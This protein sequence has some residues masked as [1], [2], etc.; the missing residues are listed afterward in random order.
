MSE[1]CYLCATTR[2]TSTAAAGAACSLGVDCDG[3]RTEA[4]RRLKGEQ[5][6]EVP[7]KKKAGVSRGYSGWADG[8]ARGS[9]GCS[10]YAGVSRGCRAWAGVRRGQRGSVGVSRGHRGL[11]GV[12]RGCSRGTRTTVSRV[13][14]GRECKGKS[15]S[16]CLR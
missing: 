15:V 8:L 4:L 16:R 9:R 6:A 13:F 5:E 12:S 7:K 10:K 1:V 14:S 11:V 3:L 2:L